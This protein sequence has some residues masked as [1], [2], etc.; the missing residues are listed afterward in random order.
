MSALMHNLEFFYIIHFYINFQIFCLQRKGVK[1]NSMI[2]DNTY[3]NFKII[4]IFFNFSIA[5]S[6]IIFKCYIYI[7][8]LIFRFK[9]F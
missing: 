3:N 8:H 6:Y 2:K 4:L 5:L 7:Y 9:L 1:S